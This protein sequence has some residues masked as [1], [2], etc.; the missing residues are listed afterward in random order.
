MPFALKEV[1]DNLV[2]FGFCILLIVI[3]GIFIEWIIGKAIG[4]CLSRTSGL[5]LGIVLIIFFPLFLM[6]IAIIVYSGKNEVS[7]NVNVNIN[8]DRNRMINYERNVTPNANYYLSNEHIPENT[9]I[10]IVQ[11][12]DSREC[13]YCAEIIKKKAKVCRFCGRDVPPIYDVNILV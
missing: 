11:K 5:V 3:F 8:M 13:P 1:M 12:N 10:A 6:G 9:G 2:V 4:K 7:S